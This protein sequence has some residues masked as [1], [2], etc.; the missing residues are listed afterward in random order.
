[1]ESPRP[2]RTLASKFSIFTGVVLVWVVAVV[3]WWEIHRGVFDWNLAVFLTAVAL[4]FAAGISRFT[5][6]QLARPLA[7]LESGIT[8]VRQG[9]LEPIQVSRTGDEIQYLGE[10]FNR[11]IF[12]LASSQEEIRQHRA[13][14]E[15]RIRQRTAELAQAMQLAVEASHAKSEFLANMSHELRTPMNGLLGMIDVALDSPLTAEQRDQLET[16]RRCGFSLLALLNDILDLSK[17]EAGK[18]TMERIAFD[19]RAVVADTI[20]AQEA[21]AQEKR[22]ALRLRSDPAT[23]AW[24]V[25]DP[26]RL[27]QIVANLLS[28]AMKFTEHGS[29]EVRLRVAAEGPERRITIEVADTGVGI[30]PEAL[31]NMFEKFTQADTS[32]TRKFGGT[33][34]GLA[35]TRKLVELFAGEIRVESALGHG[36]IFTVELTLEAAPA[37]AGSTDVAKPTGESGN[38]G[39]ARLLVV[40]DNEVNRKVILAMLRRTNHAIE[41]AVDGQDALRALDQAAVPFDLVL[42]DVQMPIMDGLEATRHIRRDPRF[43]DL[44]VI[45]MTA[46]AMTG[47]REQCLAAG[48]NEYLTKPVQPKQLAAVIE[49]HLAAKALA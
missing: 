20:K 1:M 42:M 9:R 39:R 17:I 33:G 48:M 26:L 32:I 16:A 12:A 10:S 35:I 27:R 4:G 43:R 22:I 24:V 5:I 36:S 31:P 46:H 40:E 44:P 49:S 25:G 18:M 47:D 34:L 19:L 28:N 8:S 37:P 13:L 30:A 45:A 15:E 38:T 3:M 21:R 11:M 6:R 29:V 23:P 7:L 2:R 14:L 41:V